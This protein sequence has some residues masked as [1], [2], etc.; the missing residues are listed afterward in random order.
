MLEHHITTPFGGGRF[1]ARQALTQKA[2]AERQARLKAGEGGNETGRADKWA[3]IEALT[4][5]RFHYGLNDRAIAVLEALLS[6]V[7]GREVDGAEP[8]MVFP[9]NRALSARLCGMS[10]PTLRRHLAVL[11]EQGFLIRRDSPNGKRY[12][13]KAGPGETAE[14][15][16][17]DLAPLALK[18][19]EILD[20][21]EKARALYRQE[22]ALRSQI[23][24][25]QRDIGRI[26]ATALE[27]RRPGPWE[28][29]ASRF[30]SFTLRIRKQDA[31]AD[32]EARLEGLVALR[33]EVESAYL[34]TLS[35]QEMS[36][37]DGEFERH[38]QNSNTDTSFELSGNELEEREKSGLDNAKP[39]RRP[40]ETEAPERKSMPVRLERILKACPTL[41]DYAP[42]GQ[43]RG[44]A[45]FFGV[46]RLVRSMLGIS[47]D[48]W[49]KAE[50]V[51]GREQAASVVAMMLERAEE[52]RSPGGYLRSLTAKAE[53][54]QF[55]ILPMLKALEQG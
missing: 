50:A 36:T 48:A 15:Y 4:E 18:A 41:S 14:I 5:A 55:S 40:E 51:L 3:L 16:G 52:I 25:E 7:P 38:N 19:D 24:L 9:S 45:D 54:G 43:V 22:R 10:A 34:S 28:E 46:T 13:V 35:E 30:A 32:L 49:A 31:R 21:A 17:F 11:A 44:L 47:P 33:A 2:V 42:D 26:L 27:E 39:D 20:R 8:V 29:L 6:F 1:S 12:R 37:S 23:T 53:K